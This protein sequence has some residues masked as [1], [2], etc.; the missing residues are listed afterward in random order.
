MKNISKHISIIAIGFVFLMPLAC[1]KS[2][3][4]QTDTS[5]ISEDALFNKPEDG[6]RLV[7]AIYDTFHDVDFMLK[8]LWYQANF[9]SQ[10]F[11][12]YGGDTFFETYEVPT[13]FA[14]LNIFWVRAYQGIARAN[15][16][17]PIIEKMKADGV[18]DEELADRLSGEAFFL[19]GLFYYYLAANFGGVPLEL[20][21]VTDDGLHPRNTQDEVFASVE[22]DMTTAF[23]LLQWR[24]DMDVADLGRATKGAALAYKGA[25][26]MWLKKY[27]DAVTTFDQVTGHYQ[28]MEKYIDVHEFN[29]QNNKESI[30]EVQFL[31]GGDQSWGHSNDTHWLSSFGMPEE[32]SNFGYSY[33]DARLYNSF[34]TGDTRKLATVLGPGDVHPSPAI[35]IDMYP[36]VIDNY[37]VGGVT[38]NTLGTVAN[39]WKGSDNQRSGYYG[40][41]FWRDPN[42]TGSAGPSYIFSGQNAILVRYAEILISK[43]EAQFRNSDAA[44][45]LATIQLVRDRAFGKLDNP[46]VVVPPPPAAGN[47]LNVILDEYR[48]ELSGELSLWFDMRR[49][50]EH[51]NYVQQKYNIAVPTGKDLMPIP[52]LVISAN[53]TIVQNPGY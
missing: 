11:K 10:D 18:L 15:S 53:P 27:P 30:F 52:Q 28:L 16:A 22:A 20:A 36:K 5:H 3:L 29:H 43:A 41:K 51:I 21:T 9:L 2:F 31:A 47:V 14:P 34:E 23:A 8:S 40:T 19:R 42:V 38:M 4:D 37:T 6:V 49:S 24:E 12:N 13:S 48:H 46:A 25:A 39:P 17:V 50:G 32:V 45:A 1:S 35:R 44:G 7:N 33:A 26:Q